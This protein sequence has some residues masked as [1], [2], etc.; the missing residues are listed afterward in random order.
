MTYYRAMHLTGGYDSLLANSIILKVVPDPLVGIQFWGVRRQEEQAKPLFNG[1]AFD[2]LGN[3]F[4]P[5][6]R[7]PVDNQK[8]HSF[9]AVKQPFNE[10]NKQ[11]SSHAAF[12]GHKAEFSLCAHRGNNVQAE[13][14][15]GG[16]YHRGPAFHRPCGTRM[17]IRAHAGFISKEYLSFKA[18][19]HAPNTGILFVKPFL[20]FFRLLLIGTPHR[21]LW[22]QPHLRKHAADR[23]FAHLYPK[24]LVD[25]LPNHSGC[26]QCKGK[27]QLQRILHSHCS[28]NPLQGLSIQFGWTTT[29]LASIQRTPAAVTITRHPSIHGHAM[30]TQRQ[31]HNFRTLSRLNTLD[32]PFPQFCQCLMIKP[33]R[34][35]CSHARYYTKTA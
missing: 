15:S 35:I 5:V 24:S 33:P 12:D 19:R 31:G 22:G 21:P 17:M 4:R 20:D 25:Q 1:F 9:G 34:I 3:A 29:A 26:P 7:M 18:A 2:K 6:C 28:I 27:F 16:T 8:N 11:G 14:C 30:Y 32:R 23:C 10:F 13:T